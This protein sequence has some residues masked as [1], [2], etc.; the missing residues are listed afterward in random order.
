MKKFYN[1]KTGKFDT[2][3]GRE[4][5]RQR[6]VREF[7]YVGMRNRK[8]KNKKI[9]RNLKGWEKYDKEQEKKEV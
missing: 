3:T 6:E 9:Y 5:K 7:V 1:F 4:T 8:S 2:F